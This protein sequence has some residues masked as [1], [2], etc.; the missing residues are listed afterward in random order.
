M[1]KTILIPTD[2]C[3]ES[4]NV[5]KQALLLNTDKE[6]T[7]VLLSGQ[8]L[9]D[10]IVDLMFY[11]RR[12]M[13][14]SLLKPSFNDAVS[15]LK[16]RF[17]TNLVDVRIELFHGINKNAFRNF[18]SAHKIEECYVAKH[19]VLKKT[20][21]ALDVIHYIRKCNLPV[22]EMDWSLTQ[23]TSEFDQ[24]ETLLS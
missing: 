9:S 13:I 3:I 10:S 1:K 2:F 23:S 24:L 12:K 5:L 6:L 19:Y 17:T 4:L 20:G 15:I 7:V 8:L 22:Y 16:N 21:N 14:N 18:I 11:S